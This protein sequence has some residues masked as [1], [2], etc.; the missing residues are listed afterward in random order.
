MTRSRQK[1]ACIL[2]AAVLP[3][4]ALQA[5]TV[6]LRMAANVP[7][8]SPWDIGLK[9]LAAEFAKASG[10][11]VKLVFPQTAHVATEADMLQK[12]RLGFDGALLTSYGMA[13]LDPDVLALS[14]P[15]FIRDDAEFDAVLAAVEPLFRSRI[16]DRYVMLAIAKGGWIRYFSR[17]PI[18]YPEDIEKLRISIDPSDTKVVKLMQSMGARVVTGTTA[19]FL[20]QMNSNVVDATCCSPI[21]IASLWS[22]LRG[23]VAYM[24]GYRVS[25]FIGAVVF[26]KASWNKVPAELRPQLEGILRDTATKISLDTAKLEADAIA[27]LDGIKIRNAPADYADRWTAALAQRRKTVI[28]GMFSAEML[29]RMDA[30]LAKARSAK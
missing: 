23:K 13:Q 5:Q 18:T 16:E 20:L 11:R 14:I 1:L 30:A 2:L 19:D 9:R 21:Y 10:G 28:S 4:A 3:L 24:S 25:P 29:D 17:E 15:T 12:M 6:T 8:N 27:S 7:A 22:Q 26:N